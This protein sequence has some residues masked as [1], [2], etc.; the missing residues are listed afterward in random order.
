VEGVE[1]PRPQNPH[2]LIHAPT[3]SLPYPNWVDQVGDRQVF[4]ISGLYE[5]R[6]LAGRDDSGKNGF[7]NAE[8]L[9]RASNSFD[10]AN[11]SEFCKAPRNKLTASGV[12]RAIHATD[13]RR[14][15]VSLNTAFV[16]TLLLEH[17]IA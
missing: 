15:R 3:P 8:L 9:A 16:V 12:R 10:E 7:A 1:M 11:W 4:L 13:G 5:Y 14:T 2:E 6:I 17:Y